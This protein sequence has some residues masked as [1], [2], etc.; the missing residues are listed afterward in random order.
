VRTIPATRAIE[1][2]GINTP[3]DLERV[4]HYLASGDQ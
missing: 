2:V 3:E 1:A 4:G